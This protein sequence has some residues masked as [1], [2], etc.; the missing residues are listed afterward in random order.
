MSEENIQQNNV[1]TIS[2]EE[3]KKKCQTSKLCLNQLIPKTKPKACKRQEKKFEFVFM[4]R[5]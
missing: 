4:S 1:Q 3:T 2:S 5:N